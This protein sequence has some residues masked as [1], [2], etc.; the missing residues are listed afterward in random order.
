MKNRMGTVS[1]RRAIY[2]DDNKV[3]FSGFASAKLI[4]QGTSWRTV[5]LSRRLQSTGQWSVTVMEYSSYLPQDLCIGAEVRFCK[6]NLAVL[7]LITQ[8]SKGG[9]K[10]NI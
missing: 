5:M 10:V 2:A 8:A 9:S 3:K 4:T 1:L 7:R 6:G